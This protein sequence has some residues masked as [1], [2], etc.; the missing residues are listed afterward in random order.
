[1]ADGTIDIIRE[2]EIEA[3]KPLLLAAQEG[4]LCQAAAKA[5]AE[6]TVWAAREKS[7][8]AAQK[9]EASLEEE[10]TALRRKAESLREQAIEAVIA[11]LV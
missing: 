9:A 2:A 11:A 3:K 8:H 5:A 6:E 7:A 4:E 1:M 10:L